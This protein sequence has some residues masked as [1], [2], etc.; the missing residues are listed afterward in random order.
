[1]SPPCQESQGCQFE[2]TFS[3]MTIAVDWALKTNYLSIFG[4]WLS[5]S[6]RGAH[7]HGGLVVKASAS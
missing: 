1:M 7:R 4:L 5:G 2:P 6:G 3:D